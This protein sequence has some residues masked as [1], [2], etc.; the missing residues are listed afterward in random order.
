MQIPQDD[1][2]KIEDPTLGS[3][4]EVFIVEE[5][6]NKVVSSIGIVG[7]CKAAPKPVGDAP[8]FAVQEDN[9]LAEYNIPPTKSKDDFVAAIYLGLDFLTNV[10]PP[11][12]K[13]L[14]KSS[15]RFEPEQLDNLRAK[16]LGCDP[17]YNAW[18]GRQNRRPNIDNDPFMRSAG[19]H[20][21]VGYKKSRLDT[22]IALIRMMD[23]YLGVPS[24]ILDPDRL[25]RT[26]YGKAGAYRHK[27]FGVEYR[28]LSSFWLSTKNLTGWVWENTHL[29]IKNVNEGNTEPLEHG[30]LLQSCINDCDVE[31]AKLFISQYKIPMP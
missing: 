22:N 7:G 23:V 1:L 11:Y 6:T 29:A 20:V 9:V 17:D 15:H 12:H 31:T 24:V 30:D 5:T 21:M 19:G 4:P 28:T 13:P 8:G 16:E 3:D 25:R 14:I 10:L 27:P 2:F 18:T 26:L